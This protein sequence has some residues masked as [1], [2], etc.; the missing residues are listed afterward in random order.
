[1]SLMH[2]PIYS[3]S[4]PAHLKVTNLLFPKIIP[5]PQAGFLTN[6]SLQSANFIGAAGTLSSMISR[7][8]PGDSTGCITEN[9]MG[10]LH[11]MN[12]IPI[13]CLFNIE[14]YFLIEETATD[15]FDQFG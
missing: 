4:T 15:L 2:I 9:I 11:G 5:S 13:D 3:L 12:I 7:I 14:L 10:A 1:M 8:T 6:V